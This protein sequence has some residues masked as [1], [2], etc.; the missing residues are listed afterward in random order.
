MRVLY[1]A[2][3][4]TMLCKIRHAAPLLLALCAL[5][6][7]NAGAR[8]SEVGQEPALSVIENP[9]HAP[10]VRQVAMPQPHM[11]PQTQ[12]ANSLWRGGARGFFRDQR[13]K[14][15]GDLLTVEIDIQDQASFCLLYTSPS[16]RDQRGSRMPSSA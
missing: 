6:A 15:V 4:Q 13:A 5:S 16:P 8:L 14:Q 1:S 2:V 7:C 11:Q 12:A 9:Q 10:A 3:S